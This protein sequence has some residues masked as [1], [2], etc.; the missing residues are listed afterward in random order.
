MSISA[1]ALERLL[2]LLAHP[3]ATVR[4]QG[5]ELLRSLPRSVLMPHLL[6]GRLSAVPLAGLDLSGADLSG[7]DLS[8]LDLGSVNLS[9]ADLTGARLC[10]TKLD[11]ADLTG[12]DLT[13]ADLD[14]ARL[15][16]AD[17]TGATLTGADLTEADTRGARGLGATTWSAALRWRPPGSMRCCVSLSP[18]KVT[19]IGRRRTRDVTVRIYTDPAVSAKHCRIRLHE[20][21]WVLDNLCA[22]GTFVR[23][24]PV[25]THPLQTGDAFTIGKTRMVFHAW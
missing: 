6:A 5:A 2:A 16:I 17:L 14:G 21:A 23:G 25:D 12:A 11:A 13:D 3:D 22:T 9:G 19:V 7:P 8:G 10:R 18:R 1:E 24:L 20:G 4:E 15:V